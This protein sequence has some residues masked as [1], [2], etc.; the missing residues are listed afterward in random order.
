ME[1][2]ATIRRVVSRIMQAST[3]AAKQAL[4]RDWEGVYTHIRDVPRHGSGFDS[5]TWIHDTRR[6]TEAAAAER[7]NA[8]ALSGVT[9]DRALLPLLAAAVARRGRLKVLDFGG[10]LGI[11]FVYLAAVASQLEELEY[12]I[13]ERAPL[14]EEGARL[15]AGD[16]RV[17][18]HQTLPRSVT[19]LDI[20]YLD[21]ALQY[22]EDYQ[23]LLASLCA[24]SP[25][26]FLFARCCVGNIPTYATA[27]TT[28]T[29]SSIPWWF[30]NVDEFRSTMESLGYELLFMGHSSTELNQ[31]NFKEEFRLGTARNLLFGCNRG[32]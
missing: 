16:K 10:G 30:I 7:R 23:E 25:R 31:W 6:L 1:L 26:Y 22:V 24:L 13:V 12:H 2:V 5:D 27:Q 18:F 9:N 32:S 3:A 19:D 4:R 28:L 15:F 17:R 20:V 14:C 29:G 11:S 21:S 8:G